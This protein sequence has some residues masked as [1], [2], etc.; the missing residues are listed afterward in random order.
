MSDALPLILKA[1][2]FASLKH[3]DQRRKDK[4]AS[5]YINHPIALANVLSR[6]GGVTDE[7]VLAAAILHDTLEDTQTTPA[8]L[9]EVF[10]ERIARIVEEVTDDKNLPKAERKRL[11][12]EHAPAISREAKL[13]KLADKICN[14]RDVADHPPAKW[15]I[16]RRREYF[17]WAKAVVDRLRGTHPELERRFDEVH[18][19][20]P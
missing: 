7:T 8:E 13:V 9:R 2:E 12:I 18:A 14:V 4:V 3:R 6:E 1:L 16:E 20:K 10:G 19:L 15:D 11:Q 17:D 5:P